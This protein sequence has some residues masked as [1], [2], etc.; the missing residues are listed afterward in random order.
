MEITSESLLN[1]A[2]QTNTKQ[3]SHPTYMIQDLDE[4]KSYQL[5]KR[6]EFEQQLNKNRLNYRQWIR[7][8]KWELDY[9]RD[10]R[11]AR[12]I[13]ERALTVNVEY[14]PFWTQYVQFELS[15]KNINHARNILDRGTTT[16]PRVPKLWFMYVQTEETLKNY[17]M[18]RV[19]FERW[20]TWNPDIATWD[21]YVG[22]ENR[23]DEVE[24]VRAIYLRYVEVYN[25][26]ETWLKWVDFELTRGEVIK[27][28]RAFETAVNTLVQ[29]RNQNTQPS[30]ASP[31]ADK[32]P[33]I[34]SKWA[35]WE[36][37]V[38]EYERARLIY[39]L[40]LKKVQPEQKQ[41]IYEKYVDFEKVHGNKDTIE[42]GIS[43]KRI[44]K[45]EADLNSDPNDYDTWWAY[46][47]L[48]E[49]AD[50]ANLSTVFEQATKNIPLKTPTKSLSWRR[51]IYIWVKYA[52][53][54]EF[55]NSNVDNSRNVWKNCLKIIPHKEFTF[56]KVWIGYAE[57][58]LRNSHLTSCRKVLGRAIGSS[59]PKTSLFRFYIN[60]EKKLG[61]WDRARKVYE[62]WIEVVPTVEVFLQYVEFEK[63]LNE[64][65]RCI[66]LFE[67]AVTIEDFEE[68]KV[69]LAYIE[70]HKEEMNYDR[71]RELYDE[72]LSIEDTVKV[73]ISKA[74]FESTILTEA[75]LKL[76]EEGETEFGVTEE[77]R[78]STRLIF[79]R[80]ERHLKER[81]PD[82]L[83]LLEA[84]KSYEEVHG[85][86]TSREIV[87]KRMP[88]IVKKVNESGEYVDY[89]FPQDEA[90][91]DLSKFLANAKKW[92]SLG[93][94]AA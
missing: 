44:E 48:L 88:V 80:A 18:T 60:L 73:W 53:W 8:A 3:L 91:P 70:Y 86:E 45:Y 47:K 10:F 14:I 50:G 61:E 77:H 76:E 63:L 85:D 84:W 69:W 24:R 74:L 1:E 49:T 89:L 32:L 83:V 65:E 68:V 55:T 43:L 17:E 58:E 16:L 41:K 87:E 40:I 94:G 67:L 31:A 92:S 81:K 23:Y 33:E 29:G 22:F 5:R 46:I 62:K 75:Q 54:E 90:K 6:K 27:I 38:K 36:V 66:A 25:T 15:Q 52:L 93:S 11:R 37:S 57:F 19:V 26:S 9:N 39:D 71:C 2:Y 72:L 82:R 42:S 30:Q 35:E 21:A 7:Y 12:S 34:I 64:D 4:L 79:K 59:V 56:S 13:F 78:E 20:L 28:R 51:Y